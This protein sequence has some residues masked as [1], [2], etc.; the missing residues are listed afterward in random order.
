[1]QA[2]PGALRI[3]RYGAARVQPAHAH[4]ESTLSILLAGELREEWGDRGYDLAGAAFGW[5]PAGVRHRNAF[6]PQ[7]ALIASVAVADGMLDRFAPRPGWQ[8]ARAPDLVGPLV[9]TAF[10]SPDETARREAVTDLLGLAAMRPARD[11][12]PIP[13]WLDEARRMLRDDPAGGSLA[14]LARRLGVHRVH[15]SR[16]FSAHFGLPPSL[17]RRRC[18]IART[19]ALI[20]AAAPLGEAAHGGDFSDHSHAA[21]AVKRAT[22][23]RLGEIR[24][25]V[26]RGYIRSI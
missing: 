7:G 11:R 4:D 6:G 21:R 17:Y 1:M 22:G 13:P 5:K 16:A 24:A 19:L 20:E 2:F 9:R 8:P 10:L 3:A 12:R 15:L 14:R 25:L 23:L 18:M 26:E